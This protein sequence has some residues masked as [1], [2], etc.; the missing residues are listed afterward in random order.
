MQK[1]LV[2][3][4]RGVLGTVLIPQLLAAG[5]AVR[6]TSR[7]PST[8]TRNSVEWRP[9]E[10]AS[11]QGMTEA[12]K[13]VDVI[14]HAA[15]S[16]FRKEKA[17]DVDGTGL[18]LKAAKAAG[19]GHFIYISIVGVDRVP[20]S[21]YKTKLAAEQVIRQADVPWSILRATQFHNLMDMW[22]SPIKKMPIGLLPLNFQFQP[23]SAD[24]TAARLVACVGEGPGGML[25]DIGGPRVYTMGELARSWLAAQ[26][27][28]RPLI[29]L[30]MV[31]KTATAFRNGYHTVP[32]NRY[33]KQTWETWLQ[34]L[35]KQ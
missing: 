27:M 9:M 6:G 1:V 14:I 11:G 33:G 4:G 31:G 29:N 12:V 7:N 18:L 25:E 22:F 26:G 21:Y 20:F 30:P 35:A 15:T 23:I 28:K 10:L 2:T 19:V 8:Q 5:Y 17:S 3:G 34:G 24:E 16:P 13:G 32:H